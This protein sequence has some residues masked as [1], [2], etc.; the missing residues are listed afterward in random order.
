MVVAMLAMPVGLPPARAADPDEVRAHPF[1][2]LA[3]ILPAPATDLPGPTSSYTYHQ[4]TGNRLISGRGNLPTA[5]AVDVPLLDKPE[6]VVG[7]PAG[8][9]GLWVVV[10]ADGRV[11]AF[12]LT[13]DVIESLPPE[14]LPY[15]VVGPP[16]LGL[17][18]GSI[19]LMIP[20]FPGGAP[21]THPI[22]LDHPDLAFASI[23]AAGDLVM[24]EHSRI[25][26]L[27][28]D[29]LTDG[30]PVTDEAGRILV[31][32]NPSTRYTHGILGDVPEATRITLVE[33][34]PCP[35]VAA[36]ISISSP[37]V[38][39]GLSAIWEDL[40]GDG[41]REILVTVS[42]AAE[43][44]RLIAYSE[45]GQ[46]L[47]AGPPVG[48]GYRWRHQLAVAPFGPGGE[49]EIAAVLTPHIGGVVEFYRLID[50]RLDVV[51][52]V[53]GYST[54]VIRSRNLDMALAA[55]FD[56]DGRIELLVPNQQFDT[57]GAI[58]RTVDGAEVAWSIPVG[59]R[60]TTNIAG[61]RLADGTIA[62]AAGN[63]GKT[64]RIWLP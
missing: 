31:L 23:N 38:I 56:S 10:L 37:R 63:A 43:G 27:L 55:D 34:L 20:P 46:Q 51:A 17:I 2:G 61:V 30:R 41:S 62:V 54:H 44:A 1:T 47:A 12:L 50:D 28:V 22:L 14:S 19:R 35:R 60:I 3:E 6:W 42:D 58:R 57:F 64:L 7:Y 52:R 49:I 45:A 24:W 25:T 32:T 15:P 8:T 13:G 26:Y 4:A 48:R 33:T 16:A 39:E 5:R 53:P 21:L 59:G 9:S 29:A 11:Q 18:D 40:D 36:T